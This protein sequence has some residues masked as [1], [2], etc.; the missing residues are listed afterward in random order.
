[1]SYLRKESRIAKR[2]RVLRSVARQKVKPDGR[3]ANRRAI[4][5]VHQRLLI[6]LHD[7]GAWTYHVAQWGSTYIKF[8]D[9]Q[10][11]SLRISDHQG[12]EKYAYRWNLDVVSEPL[13]VV[14]ERNGHLCYHFGP[15]TVDELVA[16]IRQW[17]K[18]IKEGFDDD[19]LWD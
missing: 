3:G 4:E 17:G 10:L 7:L 19:G 12:R 15:E 16:S 14:E 2:A 18:T 6:E 5:Q 9:P 8:A 13:C 11:G 1:M